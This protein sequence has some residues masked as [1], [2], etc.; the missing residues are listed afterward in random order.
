MLYFLFR[1][2]VPT[3]AR[4][5]DGLLLGPQ[6]AVASAGVTGAAGVII[7]NQSLSVTLLFL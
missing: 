1:L 3:Q 2:V 6:H 5:P 7:I 4:L